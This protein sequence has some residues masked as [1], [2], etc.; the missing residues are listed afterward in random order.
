MKTERIEIRSMLR[1]SAVVAALAAGAI[2]MAAPAASAETIA[3]L[4]NDPVKVT[5]GTGRVD[6][7][8]GSHTKGAPIGSGNVRFSMSSTDIIARVT[9]SVYYDDHATGGCGSV[10]VTMYNTDGSRVA[11]G[12]SDNACRTGPG[13]NVVSKPV[14]KTLR[15][16]YGYRVRVVARVSYDNGVNWIEGAYQDTYL[17]GS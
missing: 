13:A 17:G 9:G 10:R 12:Y 7:G 14:D 6:F 15:G 1:R 5:A 4:D 3:F 16:K 2:A 8:S 11:N